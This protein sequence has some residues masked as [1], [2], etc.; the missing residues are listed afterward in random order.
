MKQTDIPPEFRE[1]DA[2]QGNAGLLANVRKTAKANRSLFVGPRAGEVG[3]HRAGKTRVIY[4]LIQV[5]I[6]RGIHFTF[7][8]CDTLAREVRVCIGYEAKKLNTLLEYIAT[9]PLLI[10]DDLGVSKMTDAQGEA[11]YSIINDRY[12]HQKAVWITS[13]YGVERLDMQFG[14]NYGPK[15]GGRLAEMCDFVELEA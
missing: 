3:T 11:M 6:E 15:I 7:F 12:Q 9:A 8:D 10:L 5:M 4:Q 1:W 14:E 2:E 13:N